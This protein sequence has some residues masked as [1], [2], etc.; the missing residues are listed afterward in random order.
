MN[1]ELSAWNIIRKFSFVNPFKIFTSYCRVCGKRYSEIFVEKYLGNEV[2]CR[3]CSKKARAFSYLLSI[4]L[5]FVTN[6]LKMPK[7]AF[8]QI[9]RKNLIIKR[10]LISYLEGIGIYG[11]KIPQ[12]PGGPI[13]TLWSIT[14]KCNLN[15]THC[16]YPRK[17]KMELSFEE[18]C[19]VI[20]QLYEAKNI[21]LG[22]SGGEPLLRE[23]ILD[24]ADY[25]TKKLM[26]VAI[27]TNGTYITPN[28][29]CKLK[30]SGVEYVQISI[31]GMGTVHDQI[32]G[33]G[34]FERAV[35]GIKNSLNAKLYVS[36]DVV[37]TK[38]NAHQ[39]YELIEFAKELGVQKFEILDFVP[40]EKAANKAYLALNSL[41]MEKFGRV[42]C[43]IWEDLIANNYPLTL[44][45]KNPIFSRILHQKH[46]K[47]QVMPFFKGI[48]P[49]DA[50][51]FFNFSKRLS[52]G[53]FSE[54]NPFSPFITGCESGIYV[55]HIKTNGDVTPCP[56]N[57]VVI[58]NVK[59]NHIQQIW[60]KSTI[61]NTYRRQ[62][63]EGYC[64]KC[65]YKAICGGCR[66]KVYIKLDSHLKSDPTCIL[67]NNTV[68]KNCFKR[69]FEK[70]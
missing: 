8:K 32:R 22:L 45:Y 10:L 57:P 4:A 67:V 42:V 62:H 59:K 24:I 18:A 68:K 26:R 65:A 55:I 69:N 7:G 47:T 1:F 16:Y 40:S 56:L 33:G 46:P 13:V 34:A 5:Y 9:L 50:L 20:D 14:N 43:D 51:K 54:Q 21:V 35:E 53:I 3:N 19:K 28:F 41:Q 66:A 44:S 17:E 30:N 25:A 61:L 23:D 12:V 2:I 15:C 64:G 6:A 36:M 49:K 48:Y 29:A 31:D 52:K 27:A 63:F 58:G 37:I 70:K 39:I 38:L 11:V 60:Q